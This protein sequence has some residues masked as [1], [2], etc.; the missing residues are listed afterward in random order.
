VLA[1]WQARPDDIRPTPLKDSG[2]R[3]MTG[4]V[5][6]SSIDDALAPPSSLSPSSSSAGVVPLV[7]RG[8]LTIVS[9]GTTGL[10]TDE[11]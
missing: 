1:A 2:P 4:S 6:A 9:D 7:R 5:V 3:R 10:G 11:S 8:A